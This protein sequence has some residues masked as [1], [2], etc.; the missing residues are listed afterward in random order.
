MVAYSFKSEFAWLVEAGVKRQTVRQ[1]R[2]R[3]P[4]VVGDTFQGYVGMRTKACRLL[5][6]S[7]VTGVDPFEIRDGAVFVTG[8][9][10]SSVK[11][12][13]F[14][15][16]DGFQSVQSFLDFFR[17]GYGLPFA[18]EVVRWAVPVVNNVLY[19]VVRARDLLLY[20]N[21]QGAG[22]NLWFAP[23]NALL[24]IAPWEWSAYPQGGWLMAGRPES[25]VRDYV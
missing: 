25:W 14:A 21:S 24:A 9:K 1:V 4:T 8:E 6:R 22:H 23:G 20:F 13:E 18:G 10:L 15:R 19:K 16:L 11:L 3:R 12:E 2:Q 5:T 17:D 7:M